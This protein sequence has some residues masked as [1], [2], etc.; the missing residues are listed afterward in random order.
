M[1]INP[2]PFF[3][4]ADPDDEEEGAAE[5][6]G[7]DDSSQSEERD[8]AS[9]L[10]VPRLPTRAAVVPNDDDSETPLECE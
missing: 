1:E 6:V 5:L 8:D 4:I 2:D 9:D 10:F 7:G 3:V